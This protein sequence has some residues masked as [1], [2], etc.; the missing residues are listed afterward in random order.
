MSNGLTARE[1]LILE[2]IAS[3]KVFNEIAS[4]TGVST[5]VVKKI[6]QAIKRKLVSSLS[7]EPTSI[8]SKPEFKKNR[9]N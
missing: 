8:L 4:E 5:H 7:I 6:C 3:G 9:K 1:K 2:K